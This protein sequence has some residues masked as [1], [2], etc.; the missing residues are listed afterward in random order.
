VAETLCFQYHSY[1]RGQRQWAQLRH[2]DTIENEVIRNEAEVTGP[3]T[4]NDINLSYFLEH[5]TI[6]NHDINCYSTF[7]LQ[8]L[9]PIGA[10]MHHQ[11]PWVPR[12]QPIF[13]VMDN[14]GG[15][16]QG[17]QGMSTQED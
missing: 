9:P 8:N 14:T 11:M 13:L 12:K 2:N 17:K 7:M 6:I 5:G 16:I 10:E 15:T 1:E 4:I 3:L